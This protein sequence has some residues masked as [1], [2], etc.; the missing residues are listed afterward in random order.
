MIKSDIVYRLKLI[1]TNPNSSGG[2]SDLRI[3]IKSFHQVLRD[4]KEIK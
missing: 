4:V 1:Y 2:Q 3:I